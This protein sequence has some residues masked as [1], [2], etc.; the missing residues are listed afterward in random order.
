MPNIRM[1]RAFRLC[2]WL[3]AVKLWFDGDGGIYRLGWALTW[4]RSSVEQ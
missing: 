3:V 4:A 2:G 1:S